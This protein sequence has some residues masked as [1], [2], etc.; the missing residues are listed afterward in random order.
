[1]HNAKVPRDDRCRDRIDELMTQEDDEKQVERV[2]GMVCPEFK[3]NASRSRRRDG[4]W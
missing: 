2:F 1:M 3:K 4:R